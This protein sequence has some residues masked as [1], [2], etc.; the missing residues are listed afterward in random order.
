MTPN[1]HRPHAPSRA[2]TLASALVA[3]LISGAALAQS[4]LQIT[5]DGKR[6]LVSKDVAAERWAITLAPDGSVTGNVFF[7]DGGEPRF[8]A[9][10]PTGAGDD[11]LELSCWGADKCPIAPCTSD[12]WVF[13]ANVSLPASFF[14]PPENGPS[15][16]DA[17]ERAAGGASNVPSGLQL[18]LDQDRTLVS[19]DVGPERWAI[20]RNEDDGT[21]TGNVFFPGGDEPRFVWCEETGANDDQVEFRCFGADRCPAAPCSSSEWA[22]IAEV[23]LPV[24]F[25]QA[26]TRVPLED[27]VDAV[28]ATFGERDGFDA[29]VLALDAGYS[30]RQIVDAVLTGRLMQG[31]AIRSRRGKPEDPDGPALGVFSLEEV[32]GAGSSGILLDEL[33][34]QATAQAAPTG[35][36]AL[37]HLLA[38]VDFG[39]PLGDV[40]EAFLLGKVSL[41]GEFGLTDDA[42]NVIPPPVDPLSL[43][44]G[45]NCGDA[46]LRYGDTLAGYECDGADLGGRTCESLGYGGGSLTCIAESCRF[47]LSGCIDPSATPTPVATPGPTP[48]ATPSPTPEATPGTT[49]TPT[50]SPRP[51]P[52]PSPTPTGPACGDGV[53]EGDEECDGSD[54]LGASCLTEGF[55]GGTLRCTDCAY[56]DSD[57]TLC[58]DGTVNDVGEECDGA[59]L[60]GSSCEAR[61]FAGGTLTCSASCTFDESGC[62]AELCGNGTIDAGE[63]CDGANLGGATCA[64]RGFAGGALSCSA[65]CSFDEAGCCAGQICNGACIPADATCCPGQGWCSPEFPVCGNGTCCPA[66][67]EACGAGCMVAGAVCCET[68]ACAPGSTCGVSPCLP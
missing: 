49:P 50:P 29:V 20:T 61:G 19:K 22:E 46:V 62:Q 21:V 40:V 24:S 52:S 59:D 43:F 15:R 55:A 35:Y 3:L 58:G 48:D 30:L 18:T 47:D 67:T 25:F 27:V 11:P 1:P 14:L 37:A 51:S 4:G 36:V 17:V 65:G 10:D 9:C 53:A 7:P 8:V 23:A 41:S 6:T 12:H 31:G 44:P 39:Y 28:G 45:E 34:R 26:R 60:R 66:G 63:D 68:Y 57:C 16:D 54:L 5:P 64:S 13:I 56:D 33:R 38:L 42:G 32:A 2:A